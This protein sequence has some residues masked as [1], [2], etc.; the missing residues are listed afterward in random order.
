MKLEFSRYI[1]EKNTAKL[2]FVTNRPV[3]ADLFHA[4][5]RS[6]R[7]TD[8]TK[9]T[10]AFRNFANTPKNETLVRNLRLLDYFLRRGLSCFFLFFTVFS[11]V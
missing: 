5:R 6:E 2:H 4:D 8:M 9:L 7:Q 11:S 3:E 1:F 10:V